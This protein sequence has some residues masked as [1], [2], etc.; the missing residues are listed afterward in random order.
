MG[1]YTKEKQSEK[2]SLYNNEKR[3]LP[4]IVFDN[5]EKKYHNGVKAIKNLS[6]QIEEGEFVFLMGSSGAGKS[7]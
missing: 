5:V 4:I 6:F 2:K 1:Q 7:T 3:N